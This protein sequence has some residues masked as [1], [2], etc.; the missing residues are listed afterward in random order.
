MEDAYMK[1]E[2]GNRYG[3]LTVI[4]LDRIEEKGG[5]FWLCACDCGCMTVVR[6]NKLR[7]GRTKSCG[8]LKR[9]TSANFG[10]AT[11]EISSK[12]MEEFNKTWWTEKHR[13]EN[14]ER[15]TVHGGTHERLFRVWSH[16]KERCESTTGE[17][18]KWYHDKG[19]RVC[20]EWQDYATFRAWALASGYRN[21]QPGETFKERMSIDR[22]DP[23]KGYFPENCRWI[24]VSE[25]SK[26]RNQ[27]QANQR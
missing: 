9:E 14:R 21:P 23:E 15:S 25:N 8:C 22:I 17:H 5:A 1:N 4:C 18:A 3:R 19:I 24:T 11:R 13:A 2:T 7:T 20:D 10:N 26:L 12:R 27:Y 6:G 16:M